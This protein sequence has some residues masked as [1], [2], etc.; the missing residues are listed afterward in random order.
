M[1]NKKIFALFLCSF[2]LFWRLA[3]E[4]PAQAEPMGQLLEAKTLEVIVAGG[5]RPALSVTEGRWPLTSS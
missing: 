2:Q 3:I 4:E 5:A 1:T